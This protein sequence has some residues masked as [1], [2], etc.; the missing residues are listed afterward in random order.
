MY[1]HNLGCVHGWVI[2]GIVDE[3]LKNSDARIDEKTDY[4][5]SIASHFVCAC[6][7]I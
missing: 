7:H 2:D 1:Y 4:K 6:S 3:P 5:K